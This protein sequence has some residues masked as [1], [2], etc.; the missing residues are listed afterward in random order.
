MVSVELQN[1]K[2]APAPIDA[3]ALNQSD[4]V[5]LHGLHEI[6]LL[7]VRRCARV[8]PDQSP[9]VGQVA[10]AVILPK[11]RLALGEQ[12]KQPLQLAA[13]AQNA[14]LCPRR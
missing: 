11:R 3:V 7:A 1:A 9:S 6:H 5:Q 8:L 2:P 13:S 14:A 12:V 10:G 4:L